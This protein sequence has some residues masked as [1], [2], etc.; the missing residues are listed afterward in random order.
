[1]ID[2][3]E[4]IFIRI[5]DEII[6]NKVTVRMVWNEHLFP[7]EIDGEEYELLSPEGL[8]EGIRDLGIDDLKDIEYQYLLKVLSKPELEGAILMQE[9][10]Q[11]MENFGLYDD[12]GEL[13]PN[14]D[15]REKEEEASEN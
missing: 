8:I 13:S 11:I 1:M 9:F 14:Q 6:K 10:L 12:E 15:D 4:K 2:V 7:A 3:A 5:A